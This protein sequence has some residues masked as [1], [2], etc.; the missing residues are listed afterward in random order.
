MRKAID[1]ALERA[2]EDSR[3]IPGPDTLRRTDG[4]VR[5]RRIAIGDP[6]APIER[7]FTILAEH[8][9]LGADGRLADDVMLVS[10]GDH[11]DYGKA[12]ERARAAE[13]GLR[14]LSWLAA[15]PCDQVVI[16]A[17]NHDL[18]RVGELARYEDAGFTAAQAEA[19]AAYGDGTTDKA[20]EAGFLAR[21]PDVPSAEVVARDFSAFLARQRDLV[22][23]LLR[24][25][26]MRLAYAPA[27]DLLLVHAGITT[28][29]L[30]TIGVGAHA[31]A[32][33]IAD[34]LDDALAAAVARWKGAPLEIPGLHRP[35]SAKLG[36]GRG[37]LYHR[38][39]DPAREDPALFDGPPRRRYDPRRLPR[40]LVQ[41]IGHIRDA[42]CRKLLA[43]WVAKDDSAS[44]EG[45]LRSLRT[46]GTDV[47]YARGTPRD[48]GSSEA[49]MLFT[50]GGMAHAD[51][52][53]Y[54]LLDLDARDTAARR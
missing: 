43:G 20:L 13:G 9:L 16:L 19:D 10:M 18:G 27:K 28:D 49:V 44:P 48:A 11:F 54:A 38:P 42:K 47:L 33:D 5:S 29:D 45:G 21:H 36:E 53:H 40:G 39:S 24:G 15:H 4:K 17:G 26:R 30:E 52:D 7:F 22:L 25:R 1:A 34:A 3:S 46:D 32:A 23:A 31:S 41:A 8:A 2:G 6:Q 51:P 12:S 50:D 14:I 37:I 35:G